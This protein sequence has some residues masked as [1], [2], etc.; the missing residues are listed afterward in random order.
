M[1]FIALTVAALG[2]VASLALAAPAGAASICVTSDI[3]VNGT[4]APT[5]G[6]TCLPV[7]SAPHGPEPWS[8]G[9]DDGS[10]ASWAA[11]PEGRCRACGW[12]GHAASPH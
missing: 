8:P 6:T 7:Q 2:T 3:N 12:M 1:R 10:C 11:P 5:N 9:G 4:A